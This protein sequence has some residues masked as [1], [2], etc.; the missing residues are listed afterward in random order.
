MQAIDR[1][2]Y[3]ANARSTGTTSQIVDQSFSQGETKPCPA[4]VQQEVK[5]FQRSALKHVE[6]P[7]VRGYAPLGHVVG[8]KRPWKQQQDYQQYGVS[9]SERPA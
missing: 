1:T 9:P 8:D 3:P 5:G 4:Q 7:A 6:A 2:I